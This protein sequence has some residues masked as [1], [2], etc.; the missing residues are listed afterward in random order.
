MGK[1]NDC[2]LLNELT[3]VSSRILRSQLTAAGGFD[4]RLCPCSFTV[5][6]ARLHVLRRSFAAEMLCECA[7]G[8]QPNLDYPALSSA[9]SSAASD[10]AFVGPPHT[11]HGLPD[12]TPPDE[13]ATL[14]PRSQ[15]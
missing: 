1:H 13:T 4:N 3:P 6:S 14:P 10:S 8:L 2:G 15:T 11:D 12:N 9:H 5:G 7:G